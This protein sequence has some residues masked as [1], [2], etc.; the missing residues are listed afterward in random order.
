ML[1]L[2]YLVSVRCVLEL[3][4]SSKSLWQCAICAIVWCI[5]LKRNSHIFNGRYSDKQ[6]L[7]DRIRHL[8]ATCCK[9]HDRFRGFSLSNMLR[10]WKALLFWCLLLLVLIFCNEDPTK[11][12]KILK[13]EKNL[14]LSHK[15]ISRQIFFYFSISRPENTFFKYLLGGNILGRGT[16]ETYSYPPTTKTGQER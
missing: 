15:R 16:N 1:H 3:W 9:S 6:A 8:A 14:H 11:N 5:W 13:Q 4:I 2:V 12:K 7:W 10:D